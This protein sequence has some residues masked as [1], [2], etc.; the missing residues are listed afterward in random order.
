MDRS[1]FHVTG[2]GVHM[3]TTVLAAA[4]STGVVAAMLAAPPSVVAAPAEDEKSYVVLMSDLPAVA[5][6]GGKPGYRPTKP[7]PGEKIN[8]RAAEVRRYVDHLEDTHA[9]ALARAGVAE[10]PL[11]E[12]TY[13]ANG[14]S[15]I[16]T[17]SE[18]ERVRL[19]KG[20]LS[21]QE[22]E[23]LQKQTDTS[24]EFLG[25]DGS[26]EAWDTG[27]TGE[28]VVVGVIDTGIWPEH[29]SFAD[30]GDLPAPDISQD[31]PC[32]F[33]DTAYNP[34][35]KPFA[36]QNKLAGARDMRL[37]YNA[38]IGPE[39]YDSARDY[40]GH[41]T[42]TASTAA[43]NADVDAEIFG[44]DRGTVSGVAPRAS[45]IAYQA[46]GSLGGFGSDLA[47][48]IDQAVADGVDVI[49][50][51]IGSSTPALDGPDDIAFLFAADAGVHVATSN[52]NSGPSASTVGSPAAAPWLT[53]V[54]ASTHTRT[55]EATATL[56]DGTTFTG[57]SL[58]E[59][60]PEATLV[61]A[62]D[63]GNELCRPDI[64]FE[65]A[66]DGEVVLCAR[67]A[68]ARVDKSKA[69]WEQGG[70]GMILFNENDAQALVTDNHFLP[71][72]HISYSDGMAIR[73]YIASTSSTG[74]PG[75][76]RGPGKGKPG[77]EPTAGA[78]ASISQGEA[79]TAQGSVM[80]DFSSRGPVGSPGSADIIRPD[81]TA[82]GVNILAGNTPTPGTG[83]PGQLFQSISG[84]SMSSPHVAGLFALI[85]Q[86][87]PDW[88]AAAAKSALMTTAR[89]DVTKEDAQTAA[90]PFDMGAGH[91]DP[92]VP[93]E[94][95]S[96]FDPGMVYDAGLL[97]YAAFTCGS[98]AVVFTSDSCDWLAANGYSFD[99]AQLNIPSIGD[100]SVVASSD[101]TRS[102]TNVTE[103]ALV[104]RPKVESPQGFSVSVTPQRL[105]IP[106]RQ[107]RSFTLTATNQN[108]PVG[109]W[110][111]GAIT[112]TGSGYSARSPI[113]LRAEAIGVPGE[114]DL[115]GASGTGAVDVDFGYSG[116]Y[117]VEAFG[118]G[119]EELTNGTVA[120]DPGASFDP[121]DVGNG[122][123]M[124]PLDL[125]GVKL[126]RF[127]MDQDDV[128]SDPDIDLDVFVYGPS[129]ELVASST[130]GGT[131][132][133]IE[134]TDPEPGQY[135]LY[136]HGWGVG[137]EGDTV[138]F[139]FHSW[140]VGAASDAPLQVTSAPTS[141]TLGETGTAEFA[142][143]GVATGTT[144]LGL[145]EH[146]D[147]SGTI[148]VTRV[149]VT[150]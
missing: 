81:V 150:N 71:S 35:D 139:T 19:Q 73:D 32:D 61:D 145:L 67:G 63:H 79:T 96:I 23:L 116:D 27:L 95:S 138:D 128:G 7:A 107:S 117:S 143:D 121:S 100:A 148:G 21:V 39:V 45:V 48:A 74:G 38:L 26:G 97:D 120:Q 37:T 127:E 126:Y 122:A 13:A 144:A 53:A 2:E 57:A 62:A 99:G 140:S 109:D 77:S 49:N 59:G 8:P 93:S 22:D 83:R 94:R 60:A 68:I 137:A 84:T 51:S 6:E 70:S 69:V 98:A 91:V 147:G 10:E 11:N 46:L 41:G 43:G 111:F 108:S 15:A 28:G 5:Y 66:L 112:W 146:R 85:D 65:P 55:F 104:V 75:Q 131:D 31:V 88:S 3:R 149:R 124:Y 129:G 132:E 56:G 29:P 54:G 106:P 17:E 134:I 44:I 118:L 103:D 4:A 101:I 34:E 141:A 40:D 58:T 33:G 12:F 119:T 16:M 24:G 87:H 135:E 125:T 50:Y 110:A 92:G 105:V 25:L 114:I 89:Q 133:L 64:A 72:V 30:P 115:T 42:H 18:A 78:T 90:D 142:W 47:A 20:V 136:V 123:V 1:G 113:A 76:G 14:F 130:A 52:G 9:A 82:P 102:L 80:A 86:A 36:C